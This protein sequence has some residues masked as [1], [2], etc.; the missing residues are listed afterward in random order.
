MIDRRRHARSGARGWW[1]LPILL[2]LSMSS[3]A[4]AAPRPSELYPHPC[5]VPPVPMKQGWRPKVER[6]A[7]VGQPPFPGGPAYGYHDWHLKNES[8]LGATTALAAPR[9]TLHMIALLVDFEDQ[10]MG[11]IQHGAP[12]DSIN[13]YFGRLLTFLN[14][15]YQEV[16]DTLVTVTWELSP[17]VYRLPQDMS[18]YGDDKDFAV[19]EADLVRDA[20][21]AADDDI[22]FSKYTR[23][24][25]FH[26]G[27]GQEADVNNDSLH[28]IWSVFF[29][30]I[31]FQYWLDLPPNCIPNEYSESCIG[32]PTNDIDPNTGGQFLVPSMVIYPE[33][34]SQDGY[35]FGSMGVIA[36]E[37]GHSFGLP[38]LYDTTGPAESIYADSQG[39][40]AFGLM[41][42]G[43]WNENGFYPAEMDVWCKF[44]CGWLRPQVVR[45]DP[46]HS[47]VNVNLAGIETQGN[48]RTGALR[49]PMG[50]DEY[51]LIE[52]RRHDYN[53]NQK[54]DFDDANQDGKFDF[55]TDSYAGA[56]F[57]WYLPTTTSDYPPE[58]DGSGL[59]IYHIDE[60]IIRDLLDYNLVNADAL[61]KG[62]DVEEADGIQDLDKLILS[63]EAFGDAKD[64]W[65]APFATQFTPHT[66]PNTDGYGNAHTGIWITDISGPIP[67]MTFKV[68]FQ[69]PTTAE[70][71]DLRAGW[72]QDLPGLTRNLQPVVGDL[73]GDGTDEIVA[74]S[75]TASAGRVSVLRADGSPFFTSTGPAQIGWSHLR[76][77]P[78]LVNL[79]GDSRPELV[80][81]SGDSV[82]ATTYDGSYLDNQG[83]PQ[84]TP[85][86]YFVLPKDPGRIGIAGGNLEPTNHSLLCG[87]TA[88]VLL[89]GK[90]EIIVPVAGTALHSCSLLAIAPPRL[91]GLTTTARVAV[92]DLPGDSLL[93]PALVDIDSVDGGILEIASSVR[94]ATGGYLAVTMFDRLDDSCDFGDA[95]TIAFA[96]ADT[97]AYSAPVA[98]D[99]NRDGLDEIVVLDSRGFVHAFSIRIVSIDGHTKE[100]GPIDPSHVRGSVIFDN[101][102]FEE[103]PGWPVQVGSLADD[104]IS[105]SDIDGDGYLEVL[106][107]GPEN[108]LHVL[109]YNGTS[110]LTLPVNVPAENRYTQ[111]FLSPLTLDLDGQSGAELL[112]PLPDGQVRGHDARGRSLPEWSYLGGGNGRTY[113]VVTDLDHDGTLELVTVEDVTVSIPQD[114]TITNGDQAPVLE[115]RGR[116]VV[117][118]VGTSGTATGPWPVYR[119]DVGRTAR[120]TT[121]SAT[122]Q[123]PQSLLVEAFVVPN[124]V[125]RQDA[126]FHYQIRSTVNRVTIEVLDTRGQRVRTLEGT[127]F[128]GT[129]NMVRWPLTN[130]RGTA[131]AP[132]MYFARFE[133]ESGGSHEVHVQPFVVVR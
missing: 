11:A 17:R 19:R 21:Q 12:A 104:A 60:S 83:N 58:Q 88:D 33:T 80:W 7:T 35:Q 32:V 49:I 70:K 128:P 39:I 77:E 26:A 87:S 74:T 81:V 108:K 51:L 69:D 61:H 105:L 29:R 127:V 16:T 57:D 120:A 92:T 100:I 25:L 63:F 117:R 116:A 106:V 4:H 86:P 103:M 129:D 82:L 109:N 113:P 71:G 18:W 95:R 36:H 122:P 54:F 8:A 124:P 30:G 130:E 62:V 44:Y 48:R 53:N 68:G 101:A 107:F 10:P 40:G 9:D 2:L 28:E 13:E 72:P 20:V 27:A 79:D 78:I 22:D 56:E 118:E 98:G 47:T 126:G 31:D 133:A 93:A 66:E 45:P 15:Y 131:V 123:D 1:L 90:P 37:F 99:L 94:T 52:N 89:D 75:A 125:L 43:I 59:L 102:L 112:L 73:D 67:V 24:A 14:Q 5:F 111:P 41:G 38:D 84:P 97:I 6:P 110:V 91:P 42:A 96:E 64:S 85:A 65:W 115:R 46:S 34:E 23:F 119:H 132:G 55:W 121:P 114:G 50:G 3:G 76:A